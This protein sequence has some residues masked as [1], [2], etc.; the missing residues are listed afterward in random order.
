M[1]EIIYKYRDWTNPYHK[2]LLT[3]RELYFSSYGKLNDPMEGQFSFRWDLLSEDEIDEKLTQMTK[4]RF[5]RYNDDFVRMEVEELKIRKRNIF[6][7]PQPPPSEFQDTLNKNYGV[8]SVSENATQNLMW[9]HY[10]CGH[11]GIAIG[12]DLDSIIDHT[13]LLFENESSIVIHEQMKYSMT[14]PGLIPKMNSEKENMIIIL[15]SKSCDWKYEEEHRLI[16][17]EKPDERIVFPPNVFA[18]IHLG[19][20]MTEEHHEEIVAIAERWPTKIEVYQCSL[21][22][23]SYALCVEQIY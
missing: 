15:T 18:S 19:L 23:D 2:R 11:T 17:M 8:F 1:P 9:S 21:N 4:R 22:F 14:P 12:L 7:K 13:N 20:N 3:D 6:E 16:V 10:A 5:P